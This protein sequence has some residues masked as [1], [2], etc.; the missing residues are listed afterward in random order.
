VSIKRVNTARIVYSFGRP[1]ARSNLR[2]DTLRMYVGWANDF[3]YLFIEATEGYVRMTSTHMGT[4]QVVVEE[5]A[6]M[7]KKNELGYTLA[8]AEAE[9]IDVYRSRFSL[10]YSPTACEANDDGEGETP[11]EGEGEDKG[12]GGEDKAPSGDGA[13]GLPPPGAPEPDETPKPE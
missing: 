4:K 9:D 8:T 10:R 13:P 2:P 6:K 5:I 3:E 11:S 7:A 12:E 1:D